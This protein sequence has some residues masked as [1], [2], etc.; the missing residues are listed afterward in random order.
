MAAIPR[1]HFTVHDKALM[2][3]CRQC[4]LDPLQVWPES[5]LIGIP[6]DMMIATDLRCV[7]HCRR[8]FFR[9]KAAISSANVENPRCSDVKIA[10]MAGDF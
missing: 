3:E 10:L 8:Y 5:S 2:R 7:R 9:R 4:W 1:R 6:P